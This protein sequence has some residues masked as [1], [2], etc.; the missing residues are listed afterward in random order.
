MDEQNQ[1]TW[2]V[3]CFVY[4][5]TWL[6]KLTSLPGDVPV[7]ENELKRID[8]YDVR[9]DFAGGGLFQGGAYSRG[10][11]VKSRA[12]QVHQRQYLISLFNTKYFDI[13]VNR[14]GIKEEKV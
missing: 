6:L 2:R 10:G 12:P 14:D 11:L 9:N 4:P 7:Y 1:Q 8:E 3:F 13:N 5:R